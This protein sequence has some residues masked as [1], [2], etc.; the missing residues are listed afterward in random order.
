F[1]MEFDKIIPQITCAICLSN[2]S[3]CCVIIDF[4]NLIH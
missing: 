4:I 2:I 1:I 3:E